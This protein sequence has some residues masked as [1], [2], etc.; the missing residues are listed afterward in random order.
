MLQMK[1]DGSN[2]SYFKKHT[3]L[4]LSSFFLLCVC[5]CLSVGVWVYVYALCAYKILQRPEEMLDPL[6]LEFLHP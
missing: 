1:L 6:E 4:L 3:G 2:L 5:V